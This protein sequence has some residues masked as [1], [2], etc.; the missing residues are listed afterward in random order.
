MIEKY[1]VKTGLWE[2]GD[3][4]AKQL[5]DWNQDRPDIFEWRVQNANDG[6]PPRMTHTQRFARGMRLRVDGPWR[7]SDIGLSR[8][9]QEKVAERVTEGI[10]SDRHAGVIAARRRA[11]E[12]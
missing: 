10:S 3:N 4:M 9:Q 2:K 1:L 8:E 6:S 12:A 11:S 7:D 5:I